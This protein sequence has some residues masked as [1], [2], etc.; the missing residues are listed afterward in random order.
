LGQLVKMSFSCSKRKF[1]GCLFE[2]VKKKHFLFVNGTRPPFWP[3]WPSRPGLLTRALASPPARVHPRSDRPQHAP[4]AW[5]TVAGVDRLV[6]RHGP[7]QPALAFTHAPA[8]PAS[9][10]HSSSPS[11]RQQQQSTCG[12]AFATAPCAPSP[13]LAV[14]ATTAHRRP[15]HLAPSTSSTSC[16]PRLPRLAMVRHPS[17]GIARWSTTELTGELHS[18]D[19]PSPLHLFSPLCTHLVCLGFPVLVRHSPCRLLAGDGRR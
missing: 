14:P 5:R 16:I 11:S 4:A 3:S 18:V 8:R 19:S 10:A 6:A 7:L 15:L 9:L 1:W 13:E 2:K 17:V 12:L